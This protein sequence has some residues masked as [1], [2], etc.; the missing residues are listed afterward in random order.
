MSKPSESLTLKKRPTNLE[1]ADQMFKDAFL[2]KK[3]RF[4][5]LYPNLSDED[6]QKKTI[7]YFKKLNETHSK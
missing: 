4:S 5:H 6:L 3:T 2:I 1:M 7:D